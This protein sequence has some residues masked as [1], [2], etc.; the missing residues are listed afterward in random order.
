MHT[1]SLNPSL[2][3]APSLRGREGKRWIF[4]LSFTPTQG[5]QSLLEIS[6]QMMEE[7][8]EEEP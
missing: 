7:R 3:L 4:N 2:K 6:A 8:E 5:S 1:S